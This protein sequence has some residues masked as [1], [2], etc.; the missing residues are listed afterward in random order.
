[1]DMGIN[2]VGADKTAPAYASATRNQQKYEQSV[3]Q[4]NQRMAREQARLARAMQDQ[5]GFKSLAGA[6]NTLV[7]AKH[8]AQAL[9]GAIKPA[10][11]YEAATIDLSIATGASAENIAKMTSAAAKAALVTPFSMMESVESVKALN[12]ALRDVGA[13]NEALEPV[14]FMASTYLGRDLPRA[15]KIASVMLGG[16]NMQTNELVPALDSMIGA[17]RAAGVQVNEMDKGLK[18]LAIAQQAA[19]AGFEDM[20]GLFAL[21]VKGYRDASSAATGLRTAFARMSDVKSRSV[22]EKAL[23]IEMLDEGRLRGPMDMIGTLAAAARDYNVQ[24]GA[25]SDRWAEFTNILVKAFGQR[26]FMVVQSAITS[27]NEGLRDQ[28]GNLYK[29]AAALEFL[30]AEMQRS[31]GGLKEAAEKSGAGLLQR[32]QAIRDAGATM[33]AAVFEKV[34]ASLSLIAAS[35]TG[36]LELITA[37]YNKT[38]PLGTA[39]KW[40][41]GVVIGAGLIVAFV[42]LANVA[43]MAAGAIVDAAKKWIEGAAMAAAGQAAGGAGGAAVAGAVGATKGSSVL[44][45]MFAPMTTAASELWTKKRFFKYAT[46]YPEG[47]AAGGFSGRVLLTSSSLADKF[48][49]LKTRIG[50]FAA[51]FGPWGA[52]IG[53][54]IG[55]IYANYKQ[56]SERFDTLITDTAKT[57]DPLKRIVQAAEDARKQAW[58]VEFQ[59]QA[60]MMNELFIASKTMRTL[61]EAMAKQALPKGGKFYGSDLALLEKASAAATKGGGAGSGAIAESVGVLQRLFTGGGKSPEEFVEAQLAVRRLS[62]LLPGA[63]TGIQG[64]KLQEALERMNTE[65][66]IPGMSQSARE[67]FAFRRAA[68]MIG[69]VEEFAKKRVTENRLRAEAKSIEAARNAYY[70]QKGYSPESGLLFSSTM[71]RSLAPQAVKGIDEWRW[72]QA[73]EN[74]SRIPTAED[75]VSTIIG[76]ED[77]KKS[78]T[79]M[80]EYNPTAPPGKGYKADQKLADVMGRIEQTQKAIL[81]FS[82]AAGGSSLFDVFYSALKAANPIFGYPKP[83]EPGFGVLAGT[84]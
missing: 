79:A 8:V 51:K 12:L 20:I 83:G 27:I 58:K 78:V 80:D 21:S 13:T 48:S 76:G 59:R 3:T 56:L 64:K 19:G 28:N 18:N 9:A 17:G 15:T 2:I 31:Q 68:G 44:A 37:L 33:L 35:V 62:A 47:M 57:L 4:S 55:G 5:A 73:E 60:S 75:I 49:L 7:I 1:M 34:P 66:F 74:M 82:T 14:M 45:R 81:R 53:A 63:G 29:G 43:R 72:Q 26:A 38:G 16:M 30:R 52:M 40:L 23:G 70:A 84:K 6:Y 36:L 32:L 46:Q 10:A 25:A 42:K 24:W 54:V 67:T 61:A 39:L 50:D 22:I 71:G 41:T 11:D 69:G 77:A 65:G